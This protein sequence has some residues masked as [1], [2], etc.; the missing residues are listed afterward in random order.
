MKIGLL[1]FQN[2]V[3]NGEKSVSGGKQDT[4]GT[5]SWLTLLNIFINSPN[6]D[7]KSLLV[8]FASKIKIGGK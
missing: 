6:D 1:I 4:S 2:V 7:V 5:D 8:M 3:G